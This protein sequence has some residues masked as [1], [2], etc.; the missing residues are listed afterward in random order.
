M[1]PHPRHGHQTAYFVVLPGSC[2]DFPVKAIDL[3]AKPGNLVQQKA[4]QIADRVRQIPVRTFRRRRQ[5]RD[6]SRA[7]GRGHASY[8]FICDEAILLW[9]KLS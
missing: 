3:L 2:P 6:M 9:C 8:R 5:A 7:M 4:G 1:G